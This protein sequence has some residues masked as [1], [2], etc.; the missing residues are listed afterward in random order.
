MLFYVSY[1]CCQVLGRE[2]SIV[3]GSGTYCHS[4]PDVKEGKRDGRVARYLSMLWRPSIADPGALVNDTDE[5]K[6]K[7][8]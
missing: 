5:R 4:I 7:V 3:V 6:R 2:E 8:R 1:C